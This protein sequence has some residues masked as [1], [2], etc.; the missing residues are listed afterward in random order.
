MRAYKNYN[1]KAGE[2]IEENSQNAQKEKEPEN[3][4]EIENYP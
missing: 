4:I 1:I 2:I 3:I